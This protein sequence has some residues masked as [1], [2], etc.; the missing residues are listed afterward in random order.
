MQFRTGECKR[1]RALRKKKKKKKKIKDLRVKHRCRPKKKE[2]KEKKGSTK[3]KK[4]WE[5]TPVFVQ[6]SL[7]KSRKYL[8]FC[9]REAALI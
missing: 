9:V 2:R 6:A 4:I 7:Y 8:E 5:T 1:S 3:E